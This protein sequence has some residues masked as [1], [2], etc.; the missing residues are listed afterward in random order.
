[1]ISFFI[2]HPQEIPYFVFLSWRLPFFCFFRA[3]LFFFFGSFVF[4]STKFQSQ[5]ITMM[6]PCSCGRGEEEK[7]GRKN[8]FFHFFF[9]KN[10]HSHPP[11]G[12]RKFDFFIS[13]CQWT[14]FRPIFLFTGWLRLL[15]HQSLEGR[16]AR[17]YSLSKTANVLGH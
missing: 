17:Y 13:T 7:E 3:T 10:H 12:G 9:K 5:L 6:S 16:G 2:F 14:G 15:T 8:F 4:F 11:T 1:M